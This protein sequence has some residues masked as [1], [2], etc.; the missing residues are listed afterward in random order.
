MMSDG[1]K[2]IFCD[3]DGTLILHKSPEECAKSSNMD[4]LPGTIEKLKEWNVNGHNIILV[5]GRRESTRAVTEAGL[6]SL[7]VFYDK[8]IMGVGRGPRIIINDKKS[9]GKLTCLSFNP[10]RNSGIAS[11]PI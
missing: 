9:D 1:P 5:T 8:L 7:G 4:L 2:T 6:A 11:L 10:D 3:I